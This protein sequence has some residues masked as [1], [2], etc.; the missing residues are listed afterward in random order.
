MPSRESPAITR[1]TCPASHPAGASCSSTPWR[2]KRRTQ[3]G[4]AGG[5]Q[6]DIAVNVFQLPPG[7]GLSAFFAQV[8]GSLG[9][10]GKDY[11][12]T[13]TTCFAPTFVVH[14]GTDQPLDVVSTSSLMRQFLG[15][16]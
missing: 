13:T 3:I 7:D 2:G 14:N 10:N 4:S 6:G 1:S 9:V 5:A 8:E 11:V 12:C 15:S 16:K